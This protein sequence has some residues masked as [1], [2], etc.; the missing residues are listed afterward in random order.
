MNN[1]CADCGM[2]YGPDSLWTLYPD[3]RCATCHGFYTQDEEKT[4]DG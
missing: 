4:E 2:A 3:G 1:S